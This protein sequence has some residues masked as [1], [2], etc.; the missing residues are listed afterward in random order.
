MQLERPVLLKTI[1]NGY[2]SGERCRHRT[3]REIR[4]DRPITK[5]ESGFTSFG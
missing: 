5:I 1:R 2:G 4:M 3:H